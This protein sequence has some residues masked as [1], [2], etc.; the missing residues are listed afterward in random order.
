MSKAGRRP[1][2]PERQAEREEFARVI[3]AELRRMRKVIPLRMV[4]VAQAAGVSRNYVQ[5]VET[6]GDCCSPDVLIRIVYALGGTMEI[7]GASIDRALKR[8]EQLRP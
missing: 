4:D 8:A 7:F 2:S 1:R 5:F 6:G 3:G